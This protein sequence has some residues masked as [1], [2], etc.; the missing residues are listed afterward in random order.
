MWDYDLFIFVKIKTENQIKIHPPKILGWSIVETNLATSLQVI[1]LKIIWWKT[2]NNLFGFVVVW[3]NTLQINLFL[4]GIRK[5]KP[6]TLLLCSVFYVFCLFVLKF[7]SKRDE[8]WFHCSIRYTTVERECKEPRKRSPIPLKVLDVLTLFWRFWRRIGRELVSCWFTPL[9]F[10]KWKTTKRVVSCWTHSTRL[11]PALFRC[12]F[13]L[14]F[15]LLL[16]LIWLVG[17]R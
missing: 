3:Q 6:R 15:S 13:L 9:L 16:L 8:R 17:N 11:L 14:L 12:V 1:L 10:Q 5:T 4:D 2:Y 7:V